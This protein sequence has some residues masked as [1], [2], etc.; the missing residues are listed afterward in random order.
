MTDFFLKKETMSSLV[1]DKDPSSEIESNH[2]DKHSGDYG[3]TF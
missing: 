3:N 2:K 1:E